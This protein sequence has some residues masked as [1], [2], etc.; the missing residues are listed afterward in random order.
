MKQHRLQGNILASFNWGDY[1]ISHMAPDSKVFIDGRYDTVYPYEIIRKF[2]W[3]NYALPGGDR[4]LE[5]F[6]HD[7]VLIE[8]NFPSRKM[9]DSR[10]DWKLIYQDSASRLYARTDSAA[11]KIPGVPVTGDSRAAAFP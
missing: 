3:F 5:E 6:P 9:M 7:Y 11:A 1:V 4:I 2:I 10:A 8:P